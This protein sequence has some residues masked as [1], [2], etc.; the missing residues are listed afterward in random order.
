MSATVIL[1]GKPLQGSDEAIE[2]TI[3][4][5]C[6]KA[7]N[8]ASALAPVDSGRLR[9]SIS[10][11]TSESSQG[12]LSINPKKH[13]GYVGTN[14]KYARY[15]EYGTR[16]QVAQPYLRPAIKTLSNRDVEIIKAIQTA[17]KESVKKGVRKI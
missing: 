10:Y 2:K 12:D 6:I 3:E 8:K 7:M 5:A 11:K 16:R 17:M 1:Y 4:I 13:E 9:S 14:V 15:V